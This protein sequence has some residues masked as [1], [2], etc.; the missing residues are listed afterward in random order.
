M[1]Q[2]GIRMGPSSY[3]THLAEDEARA[4][5]DVVDVAT[6]RYLGGAFF[7]DKR[8]VYRTYAMAGGGNFAIVDGADVATF[9]VLGDCYAKDKLGIYVWGERISAD[10][11]V[12]LEDDPATKRL[13]AKLKRL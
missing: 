11:L 3:V 12:D 2:L 7:K 10:E 1:G 8:H 9:Q 13:L 6:F 5:K 4:I